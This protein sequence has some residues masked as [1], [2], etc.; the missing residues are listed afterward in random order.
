MNICYDLFKEQLIQTVTKKSESI[1]VKEIQVTKNNG[2]L[3]HLS[4]IHI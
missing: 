3:L 4:L 2:V 1:M